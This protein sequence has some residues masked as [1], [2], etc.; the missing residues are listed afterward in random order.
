MILFLMNSCRTFHDLSVNAGMNFSEPK[1]ILNKI[2]NPVNKGVRLSA[3][4][5]G[6]ATVLL[7][8]DDKQI[9]FYHFFTQNIVGIKRR[10][11]EH[12]IELKNINS[13]T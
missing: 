2:T 5:V 4:W 10:L 13:A 6:H 7:Q 9:L 3:L 12:G 8:M 1:K 11:Y